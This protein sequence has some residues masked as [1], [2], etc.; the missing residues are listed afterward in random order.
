MQ[1]D[2]NDLPEE[3]HKFSIAW[4]AAVRLT[5]AMRVWEDLT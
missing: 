2:E 3:A 4:N 5:M 1:W